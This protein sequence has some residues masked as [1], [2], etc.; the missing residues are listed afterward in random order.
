MTNEHVP[1]GW[2]PD[3]DDNGASQ[4]Y[5]DGDKWTEQTRF[6]NRPRPAPQGAPQPAG[7]PFP[8]GPVQ[9]QQAP[10]QRKS[11]PARHKVFSTFVVL[12][13]LIV[14]IAVA[15]S[16][17]GSSSSSSSGSLSGST[18]T[19]GTGGANKSSI[20]HLSDYK[21]TKCGID[22]TTNDFS[23]AVAI[24]NTS[25]K[26]SNYLGTLAWESPDGKTQYDTS[27][28]VANNLAPGQTTSV[29]GFSGKPGQAGAICKI[30]DSTRL[31][32]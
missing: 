13:A 2:Y 21:I 29:D 14:I 30:V 5:W 3:P 26:P 31:A 19:S 15:N 10:Q 9:P 17:G 11:F 18:A 16:G 7:T 22:P 25:S 20:D 32:S 8:S 24:T 4:R 28:V 23:A 27:P 12:I 1:A 6:T